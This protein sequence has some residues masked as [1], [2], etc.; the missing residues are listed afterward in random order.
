MTHKILDNTL[1]TLVLVF[2]SLFLILSFIC[3]VAS[4]T[5]PDMNYITTFQAY[6]G[7]Y[8]P[9]SSLYIIMIAI[10]IASIFIIAE[11]NLWIGW[12]LQLIALVPLLYVFI[13]DAYIYLLPEFQ[14]G[15]FIIPSSFMIW[16]IVAIA[17]MCISKLFIIR[18]KIA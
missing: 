16:G 18:K 2:N 7:T 17:T 10:L 12:A 3:I 8:A 13:A 9:E 6:L 15:V 14:Y 1:T 4:Y 5:L 11:K